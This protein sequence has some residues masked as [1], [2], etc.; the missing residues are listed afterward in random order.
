MLK[1][2]NNKL[3]DRAARYV[4]LLL[5]QDNIKI[6]YQEIIRSIFNHKEN[7]GS[8]ESIVMTVYTEL[9]QQKP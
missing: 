8:D 7:V 1:T 4:Q 9:K 5:K 2:S 6:P 3:I